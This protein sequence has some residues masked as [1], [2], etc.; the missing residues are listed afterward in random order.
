M[1]ESLCPL[2]NQNSCTGTVCA[3]VVFIHYGPSAFLKRTLQCAR[4][5]NPEKVTYFLGD[6]SN[7]HFAG[8]AGFRNYR[9]FQ[10]A[11]KVNRFHT[12]FQP[13]EGAQHRL[14]KKSGNEQWLRFVFERWFLIL[15][16][17]RREAI[18]SFWTFD[19]DTLLL[20]P[21]A[22]R[23]KRFTPYDATTQ[24]RDSCLN[25]FVSSSCLVERYTDCVLS[26]FADHNF[27]GIQRE[28]LKQHAG[29]A[30]NEMDTFCEFRRRE[31]VRTYHAARPLEGEFFDDALAYDAN[32]EASPHKV[33]GRIQVKRL[34]C[35]LDGALY[36]RHL[37]SGQLVRMVTCNLS[38]LPDY[39]GKKL[40]R[41]CLTPEQDAKVK[42]PVESELSEV[43]L[44]QPLTDRIATALRVKAF[45]M[46]RALGC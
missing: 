4:R 42:S 14:S 20:A 34:W 46:K 18:G 16:F 29:L 9:E 21:L 8:M 24:C 39:I 13:I 31:N 37:A 28:R 27:L 3:P 2:S 25:G 45:E 26:L 1:A 7:R 17:L 36:A 19:S 12:V 23:E 41:F 6:E 11:E 38:W 33:A 35:S 43:D 30:F 32:F 22:S 5:S 40:A 10:S 15:E 44:S